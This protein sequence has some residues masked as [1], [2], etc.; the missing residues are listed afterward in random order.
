MCNNKI[1]TYKVIPIKF[2]RESDRITFNYYNT[3]NV[4]I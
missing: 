1:L 4:K 2:K 3:T